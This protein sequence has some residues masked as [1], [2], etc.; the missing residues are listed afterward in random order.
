M[1]LKMTIVSAYP[2]AENYQIN[3]GSTPDNEVQGKLSLT[4]PPEQLA[5]LRIG[6]EYILDLYPAPL[7]IPEEKPC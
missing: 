5:G 3:L 4:I 1:R 6:R 2:L 7:E